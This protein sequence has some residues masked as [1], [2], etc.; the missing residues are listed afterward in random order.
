MCSTNSVNIYYL[1]HR[2]NSPIISYS[3]SSFE[4]R[5]D[6]LRLVSLITNQGKKTRENIAPK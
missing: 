2:N 6:I 5:K 1:Y 3:K 4:L